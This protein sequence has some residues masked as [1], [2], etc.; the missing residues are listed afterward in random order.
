MILILLFDSAARVSEISG[1]VLGDLS[2]DISHPSIIIHGKGRKTRSIALSPKCVEH[3][4][5][6]IRCYHRAEER[7]RQT[8]SV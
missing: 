4:K 5:E 1:I 7:K 8:I 6:Y 3:M 2:L